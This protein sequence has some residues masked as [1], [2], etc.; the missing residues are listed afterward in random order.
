MSG[1]SGE[2]VA[3]EA[4]TCLVVEDEWLIST[5]IEQALIGA[6]FRVASRPSSV[7]RALAAIEASPPDCAILDT[8]LRGESSE[9][10]AKALHERK[11]PFLVISGLSLNQIDGIL[12]NAPFL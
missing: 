6:G 12:A 11:I 3:H 7:A 4:P 5:V 9:A 8:D 1:A 2:S 10:V